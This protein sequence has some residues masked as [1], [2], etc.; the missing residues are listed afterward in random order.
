MHKVNTR[1]NVKWM[2][3]SRIGEKIALVG[4]LGLTLGAM[5]GCETA[6]QGLFTGAALGAVTGLAIG[7]INGEAGE[8]AAVGAILGGVAGSIIGD[9]NDDR[10]QNGYRYPRQG[11]YGHPPRHQPRHQHHD[12]CDDWWND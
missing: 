3:R 8:G 1:T 11:S 9:Q 10:R 4:L 2:K 12:R 6:G 5:G 7:S